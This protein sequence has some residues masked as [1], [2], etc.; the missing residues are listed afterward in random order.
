MKNQGLRAY[1]SLNKIITLERVIHQRGEDLVTIKF[2]EVL[3]NLR[4]REVTEQDARFLNSRFL[5]ELSAEERTRFENALV[6]CSIKK[7]VDEINNRR[8]D[9]SG[10]PVFRIWTKKWATIISE[11]A[12]GAKYSETSRE[13]MRVYS[14]LTD[15]F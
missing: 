1:P 7:Q 11:M 9:A 4:A 3:K 14:P 2:R 13:Q 5:H 15:Y 12:P 10:K 8:M 6:L